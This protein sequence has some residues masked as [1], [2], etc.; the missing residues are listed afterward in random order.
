[1]SQLIKNIL[2]FS[3]LTFSF[4][5]SQSNTKQ[6]ELVGFLEGNWKNVTISIKEGVPVKIEKYAETMMVKSANVITIIA[7]GYN[8][9]RDLTRD[10]QLILNGDQIEMKQGDFL[11]KGHREGNGYY[12]RGEY[13]QAEYRFRLYTLGDKFVFQNEKWQNGKLLKIEISY[14]KREK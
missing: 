10:M 1:M 2:I 8:N 6:N 9:G 12:L 14:L 13:K 3:F 11:A 5:A 7:H 4:C